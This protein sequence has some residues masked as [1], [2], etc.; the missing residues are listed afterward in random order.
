MDE[1][2]LRG[3][4]IHCKLNLMAN[5]VINM[6]Y[7]VELYVG[8]VQPKDVEKIDKWIFDLINKIS[9]DLSLKQ[10]ALMSMHTYM[11]DEAIESRKCGKES[12]EKIVDAYLERIG[13]VLQFI[14]NLLIEL[15]KAEAEMKDI[16]NAVQG[17]DEDSEDFKRYEAKYEQLEKD[18][19]VVEKYI[20]RSYEEYEQL[21]FEMRFLQDDSAFEKFLYLKYDK[22]CKMLEYLKAMIKDKKEKPE[23]EDPFGDT[24]KECRS[25]EEILKHLKRPNI[26]SGSNGLRASMEKRR[27][28]F[29]EQNQECENAKKEEVEE[30]TLID[31]PFCGEQVKNAFYCT[32]CGA[33]LQKK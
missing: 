24:K 28:A 14:L 6:P 18:K 5:T 23:R 7:P 3:A 27:I 8:Q 30:E 20:K 21:T 2:D 9:D 16:A 26:E 25:I 10:F 17:L 19:D 1:K 13:L 33:R 29:Q 22:P 15:E 4:G 31:C 32:K 12:H 11:L